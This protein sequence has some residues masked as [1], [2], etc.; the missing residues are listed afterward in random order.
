MRWQLRDWLKRYYF[1]SARG[2][3]SKNKS[4]RSNREH[5]CGFDRIKEQNAKYEK[6][7]EAAREVYRGVDM[8]NGGWKIFGVEGLQEAIKQLGVEPVSD[9]PEWEH[10][11]E[12]VFQYTDRPMEGE[13]KLKS[14][15]RSEIIEKICEEINSNKRWV[16]WNGQ[17][18]QAIHDADIE[19]V[20]QHWLGGSK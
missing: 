14:F 20:K 19:A 8:V 3:E 10:K 18:F 2:Y 16:D 11:F 12:R 6:V 15:I 7:V 1:N 17:E 5:S 13:Q 4:Q 9:V